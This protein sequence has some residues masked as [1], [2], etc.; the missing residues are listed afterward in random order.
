M[1]CAST[2]WRWKGRLGGTASSVSGS[3]ARSWRPGGPPVLHDF[4]YERFPETHPVR[5]A[6]ELRLLGYPEDLVEAVLGHGD[7]TGVPR[8]SLLA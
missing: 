3:A 7:H 2:P 6:E 4:D 8:T 5:G 1:H